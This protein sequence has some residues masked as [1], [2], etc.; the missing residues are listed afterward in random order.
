MCADVQLLVDD[1]ES[2]M[3]KFSQGQLWNDNATLRQS[4]STSGVLHFC[5]SSDQQ[6]QG[7][8][9]PFS[10][11]ASDDGGAMAEKRYSVVL[12]TITGVGPSTCATAPPVV[13]HM[14]QGNITTSSDIS[15]SA[16]VTDMVG[17]DSVSIYWST[18]APADPQNPDLTV[19]NA[20]NMEF[21]A[22]TATD[23]TYA[24]SIPNPTTTSADPSDPV[25]YLIQ[26]IDAN[27]TIMGCNT[28]ATNS[29]QTGVNMFTVTAGTN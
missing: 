11:I 15:L 16:E 22:G 25:Y 28:M 21:V 3:V 12:G 19:M 29:P 26:A 2:T 20:V 14:P 23:G 6:Q 9:F 7:T 17:I 27:D 13:N 24:G 8:I 5:P 10:V 18:T 4:D 1:Q